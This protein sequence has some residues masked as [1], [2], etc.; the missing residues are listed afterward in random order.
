MVDGHVERL[1]PRQ[2]G[3]LAMNTAFQM[4]GNVSR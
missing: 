4:N 1:D 2:A 3:E